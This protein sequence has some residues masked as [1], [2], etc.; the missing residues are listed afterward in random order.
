[1]S[2]GNKDLLRHII[3]YCN[4]IEEETSSSVTTMICFAAIRFTGMLLLCAFYKSASFQIILPRIFVRQRLTI[5]HE[6]R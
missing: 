1:M 5:S 2:R 3:G 6:S 4:Q